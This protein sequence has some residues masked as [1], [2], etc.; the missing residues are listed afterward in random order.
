MS[1]AESTIRNI[2]DTALWAAVYRARETERPDA[3]FSD[4]FARRLAGERGERI[5]QS[6]SFSNRVTWAWI[7][8]TYLFDQF[9]S[10]QV[11][12]GVDLVINLAAGLDARPYRMGLPSSLQWIEVDLPDI[13]AY[14]EEILRGEKPVC[15]VERVR[16]DLKDVSA[17]RELFAQ[18]GRS[19]SKALI[20]SEGLLIYLSADEVA[21]LAE[22]LATPSSFKH[23]T[24]D[25]ASPGLLKMTQ[26]NLGK[27]INQSGA[28]LKFGPREGPLFFKRHGWTPV[29][30]RS[31]LKTAGRLKRLPLLMRLASI[32]PDSSGAQG[33][34]PWSA[35]CLMARK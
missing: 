7:A 28:S 25:I 16:L 27:Q 13:L 18:L 34:R 10:E 35:V 12:Q 6:I 11:H 15:T 2:S 26:R 1:P 5:A 31:L 4:P 17:R 3:L 20:I 29:D 23:W 22:D 32:F 9:I 8:R 21:A 33:A 19:A 24:L 30:V 14:K